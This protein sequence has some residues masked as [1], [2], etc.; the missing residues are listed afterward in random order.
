MG[1]SVDHSRLVEEAGKIEGGHDWELGLCSV[2][3]RN[4]AYE[5]VLEL[6]AQAG[7]QALEWG[8][9]CHVPPNNLKRAIG[10]GDR[11]RGFGMSPQSLGSYAQ[12]SG[13]VAKCGVQQYIDCA[14]ALGASNI[15]VWAGRRGTSSSDISAEEYLAIARHFEQI[16]YQASLVGLT[17]SIEFHRLTLADNIAS[18]LQLIDD[19]D[20][21]N[22]RSYWQRLAHVDAQ[23]AREQLSALSSVLSGVHV[24]NWDAHRKRFPLIEAE[25]FWR[26]T[27]QTLLELQPAAT[28]RPAYIEFVPGDCPQQF[29]TDASLLTEMLQM[30]Q[31]TAQVQSIALR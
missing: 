17:I 24:F 6:C 16:A 7:V 15:R 4:L 19:V 27:T 9:D 28:K 29:L 21:D 18:V 23:A 3:F 31:A 22:L 1:H 14:E 25:P 26:A 10:V 8:A 20:A 13:D 30:S 12:I 11:T 2:T 5:D